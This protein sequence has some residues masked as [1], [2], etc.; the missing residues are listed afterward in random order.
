MHSMVNDFIKYEKEIYF[1]ITLSQEYFHA[2]QEHLEYYEHDN[3]L[4]LIL[5]STFGDVIVSTFDKTSN[6]EKKR[7]LSLLK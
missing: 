2:Y 4:F 6:E 5:L 7:Y 1:F 3:P